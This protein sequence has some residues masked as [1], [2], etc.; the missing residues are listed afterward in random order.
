MGT[1]LNPVISPADLT[2][3]SCLRDYEVLARQR[4]PPG[5]WAY[6]NAGAADGLT[7]G[8]NQQA[9]QHLALLPRV[10]NKV[11]HGHTT[12]ELLG[13]KYKYPLFIAPMAYHGLAHPQAEHATAVAA[14]AMQV[15]WIVSTQ[16]SV[17]LEEI[18]G[19]AQC[20]LWFQLYLQ[21]EREI[22]LDLL[23]RAECSGYQAIVVTVD[24]PIQGLRNEDQRHGFRLPSQVRAVNLDPY[25]KMQAS[26]HAG[27]S[28]AAGESLFHHPV[29]VRMAGWDDLAWLVRQTALPVLVKGIVHPLDVPL[30]LDCGVAGIVVSNH[31][32]RVLD[33]TPAVATILP[34]IVAEVRGRVPV[35]AD[36]GIRRGTDIIKALALGASAVLVGRPVL[37]GLAVAAATG[38]VHVLNL[39]CRELE[40]AMV[41]TG[42]CTLAEIHP[43]LLADPMRGK[44]RPSQL[45]AQQPGGKAA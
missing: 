11:A 22:S 42:C 20:P 36:G 24:A 17:S 45:A 37:H 4:L 29:I 2:R 12:L 6:L 23:R 13:Q 8:W 1:D 39:L 35:L 32:G 40:A 31:G 25:V 27:H 19:Q 34:Q 41:L 14:S 9:Y 7:D 38:V 16:S 26:T 5:I 33:T 18:A 30:A 15:P 21:G 3:L 10:L 44:P 43:G 28:L